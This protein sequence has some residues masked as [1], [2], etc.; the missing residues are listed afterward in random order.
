MN[1]AET[2]MCRFSDMQLFNFEYVYYVQVV[3]YNVR[4][5]FQ[6]LQKKLHSYNQNYN[7]SA[8]IHV[9]SHN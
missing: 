1:Y 4:L 2:W 9:K 7:Y 5:H 8:G 6:L 3:S